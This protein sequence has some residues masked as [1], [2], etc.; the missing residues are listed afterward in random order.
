MKNGYEP[1]KSQWK[2]ISMWR[3]WRRRPVEEQNDK[4]STPLSPYQ[5]AGGHYLSIYL[6]HHIYKYEN[7]FMSTLHCSQN[8]GR[9]MLS[10]RHFLY[11]AWPSLLTTSCR[12]WPDPWCLLGPVL[13]WYPPMLDTLN[14]DFGWTP[15]PPYSRST[16]CLAPPSSCTCS[17]SCREYPAPFYN[18]L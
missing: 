14:N 16:R 6:W 3:K 18:A 15:P 17:W 9:A 7:I 12:T 13:F 11:P 10:L 4:S 2:E 5:K 8:R 1:Y